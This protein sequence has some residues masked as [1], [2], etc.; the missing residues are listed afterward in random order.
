MRRHSTKQILKETAALLLIAALIECLV[1]FLLL[2]G[3]RHAAQLA[4]R[5]HAKRPAAE[6]MAAGYA[7]NACENAATPGEE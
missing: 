2:A 3:D 6:H 5:S 1:V 4:R 7:G